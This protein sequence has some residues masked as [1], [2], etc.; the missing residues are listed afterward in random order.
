MITT[1][2]IN[3]EINL[4][5]RTFLYYSDKMVDYLTV[6][7]D[8]YFNWYKD[9]LQLEILTQT[10]RS[11]HVEDGLLYLGDTEVSDTFFRVVGYKVREYYSY[12][13]DNVYPESVIVNP[14]LIAPTIPTGGTQILG[15]KE[16]TIIVSVDGQTVVP[17]GFNYNNVDKASFTIT[18][19]DMDPLKVTSGNQGYYIEDNNIM[20]NNYYDLNAGD[21]IYVN[22]RQQNPE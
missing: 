3:K 15:W 10:L 1:S 21:K 6:G 16:R 2:Y 14:D 18:V 4:A 19:N 13:V 17:L 12:K 20:W 22:Y 7:S 11:L 8:K 9:S 5:I